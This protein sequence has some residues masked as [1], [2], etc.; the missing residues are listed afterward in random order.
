MAL[1]AKHKSKFAALQRQWWFLH[2]SEKFSSDTKKTLNF[3]KDSSINHSDTW[4]KHVM[5]L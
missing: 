1:S 5:N 4:I 3:S 2:I